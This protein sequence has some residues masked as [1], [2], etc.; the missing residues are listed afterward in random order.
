ML[1]LVS[2]FGYIIV[3]AGLDGGILARKLAD[4]KILIVE[5]RNHIAGNTF[6]YNDDHDIKVKKYGPH[7]LHT[8]SEEVFIT[9]FCEPVTCKTKCEAVIDGSNTPSTFNFKTIDQ[10]YSKQEA[11]TLKAKLLRYYD[12]RYSVTVVEKRD[13]IGA[14]IRHFA[15][16]LFEK[17]YKL[18]TAKQWNLQTDEIDPSVLK[19]V[20]IV[21]SYGDTY[22]YDKYEFI[23]KEGITAMYSN[24][25]NHPNITI[26][27][28]VDALDHVA[29]DEYCHRVLYDGNALKL[30]YTGAIGELFDYKF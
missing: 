14:D 29:I 21:L 15:E 19:R 5:R 1:K 24:I 7:V 4:K 13:S 2:K 8:N 17:D 18:Y 25:V 26:K 27:L 22:F 6:D 20:P 30:V 9:Q 23:P 16:F 28:G 10:F 11:E 3:G 12:N